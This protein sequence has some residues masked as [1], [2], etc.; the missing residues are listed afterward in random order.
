MNKTPQG[1][2]EIDG[3]ILSLGTD[4]VSFTPLNASFEDVVFVSYGIDEP[5]YSNYKTVDV[6]GKLVFAI[7]G[8]PADADG[9]YLLS[10]STEISKWSNRSEA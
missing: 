2:I 7:S 9:N 1:S 8:E 5:Q 6:S 3:N 10:G 4:F